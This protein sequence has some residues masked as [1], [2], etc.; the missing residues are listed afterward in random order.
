MARSQESALR[1]GQN[2]CER[3]LIAALSCVK[4]TNRP[5]RK[6][7]PRIAGAV[8]R[9]GRNTGRFR[10]FRSLARALSCV[11]VARRRRSPPWCPRTIRTL[12]RGRRRSERCSAPSRRTPSSLPPPPGTPPPTH[13]SSHRCHRRRADDAEGGED[14]TADDAHARPAA[15]VSVLPRRDDEPHSGPRRRCPPRAQAVRGRIATRCAHGSSDL[16]RHLGVRRSNAARPDRSRSAEVRVDSRGREETPNLSPGPRTVSCRPGI[17]GRAGPRRRLKTIR[18]RRGW[19]RPLPS[20]PRSRG[21]RSSGWRGC[22][23][24]CS[25]RSGCRCR[26]SARRP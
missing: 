23:R 26:S 24:C 10:A 16:A 13:T 12:S 5:E 19:C 11:S 9:F 6:K 1:N 2:A 4:A 14:G 22:S 7:A 25:S 15:E 21:R 18:R 3:R 17:P 8:M 20:W